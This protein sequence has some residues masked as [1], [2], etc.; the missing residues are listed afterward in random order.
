[1]KKLLIATHNPGKIQE[2]KNY[3]GD[4]PVELVSLSDVGI[5]HDVEESGVTYEENSQKKAREYAALSGLP[6]VSDDGGIEIAALNNEPGVRSKRWLGYEATDEELISNMVKVA[7]ELP[8][9]NRVAR[10]RAV[11]SL[12]LPSGEVW[13]VE[14]EVN[15][16]IAKEPLGVPLTGLPYRLFFY[17]PEINKYYHE[18]DLPPEEMKKYNHRFKAVQKLKPVIRKHLLKKS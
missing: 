4:L 9:T 18:Q 10:F 8:D 3:L 6:A 15:G 12:A 11:L 17:L 14:D 7:K 1:M 2:L 13:S 16:I 5:T